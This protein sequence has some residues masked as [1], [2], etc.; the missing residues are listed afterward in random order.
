MELISH[1]N[2][3]H[4]DEPHEVLVFGELLEV[5]SNSDRFIWVGQWSVANTQPATE[6]K[7]TSEE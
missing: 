3:V 5:L 1:L 2:E 4:G 7:K 6:R